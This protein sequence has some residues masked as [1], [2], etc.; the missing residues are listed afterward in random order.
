MPGAAGAPGALEAGCPPGGPGAL[1]AP[2][3]PCSP[4]QLFAY[5]PRQYGRWNGPPG[6]TYPIRCSRTNTPKAINR[7]GQSEPIQKWTNPISL[8]R[9][10][11]PTMMSTAPQNQE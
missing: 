7:S 1:G 11:P 5:G 4:E 2:G 10:P 9:P 8:M 6:G 3:V